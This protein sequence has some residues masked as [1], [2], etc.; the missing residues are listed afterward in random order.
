[1]ALIEHLH[2]GYKETQNVHKKTEATYFLIED[3]MGNKYLQIDTFG[4][5]EREIP[6]KVS[7]SIQFSP[8]AIAQLKELLLQNF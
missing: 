6:G 5:D 2:K 1:M 7:Q 3:K 4:S 8:E